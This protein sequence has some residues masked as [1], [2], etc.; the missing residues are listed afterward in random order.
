MTERFR[1]ALQGF[2]AFEQQGLASYFRLAAGPEVAFDAVDQLADS[3]FCVVDAD[4]RPAVDAVRDAGRT[5]WAVFVGRELPKGAVVHL[6]RPI[7]PQQVTRALETLVRARRSAARPVGTAVRPAGS[8]AR[9]LGAAAPAAEPAASPT[10]HAKLARPLAAN[11]DL[12]V[13]V[14]DHDAAMRVE[15]QTRLGALGCRVVTAASADEAQVQLAQQRFRVVFSDMQMDGTDGLALCQDIKQRRRGAPNVVLTSAATSTSDRVRAT[16]A[17]G[18]G[19]LAKPFD[20]DEL[21]TVLRNCSN[22]RRR[23]R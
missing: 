19:F 20:T 17:G 10:P 8:A 21:V 5:E 11:F 9:P 18:D 1:I 14:V 3:D 15:L 13:L 16:L 12:D 23:A 6:A 7:D 22:R 4:R 2:S